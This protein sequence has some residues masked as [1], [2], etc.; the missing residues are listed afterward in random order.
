MAKR[1]RV[2]VK[3]AIDLLWSHQIRRE[4]A[5]LHKEVQSLREGHSNSIGEIEKLRVISEKA[6]TAQENA[7]I[8][9]EQL[10]L[11]QTRIQSKLESLSEERK[12]IRAEVQSLE[13]VILQQQ[14]DH[15]QAM[16]EAQ[17]E[18]AALRSDVI[19]H[20]TKTNQSIEKTGTD[21][22]STNKEV[23]QLRH[24][25]DL[26]LDQVSTIIN[27]ILIKIE[28]SSHQGQATSHQGLVRFADNC[29]RDQVQASSVSRVEESID[30]QH[31]RQIG[32]S[33]LCENLNL[34]QMQPTPTRLSSLGWLF[35]ARKIQVTIPK[36]R[37]G[38]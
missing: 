25:T 11:E 5:A 23:N 22:L 8:L 3:Q 12:A 35:A 6:L 33:S 9:M 16:T 17:K 4:N 15:G 36:S 21:T 14:K 19:Y 13:S 32:E 29:L 30:P 2:D 7:N 38:T 10:G 20:R 18:M 37:R 28:G 27:Q 1:S 34:M 26:R 31:S 24:D